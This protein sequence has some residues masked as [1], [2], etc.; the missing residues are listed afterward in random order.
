MRKFIINIKNYIVSTFGLATAAVIIKILW[1]FSRHSRS[2]RFHC[3]E[4]GLGKVFQWK[5][6]SFLDDDSGCLALTAS[7]AEY[8]S[9]DEPEKQEIKKKSISVSAFPSGFDFFQHLSTSSSQLYFFIFFCWNKWASSNAEKKPLN[10][11]SFKHIYIHDWE[12]KT[13]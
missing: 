8:W 2:T 4:F 3:V 13:F 6:V 11:Y 9:R 7:I 5:N 12:W 10:L 1:T